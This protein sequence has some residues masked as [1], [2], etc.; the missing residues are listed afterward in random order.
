[1]K[2][3][4]IFPVLVTITLSV[5]SLIIFFITYHPQI[6]PTKYIKQLEDVS[7]FNNRIT[8]KATTHLPDNKNLSGYGLRMFDTD[9]NFISS[10]SY[11]STN[12]NFKCY[13]SLVNANEYQDKVGLLLFLGDKLLEYKVDNNLN[14]QQ[15][16]TYKL[17]PFSMINIPVEFSISDTDSTNIN[18]N[19]WIVYLYLLDKEPQ[20]NFHIPYFYLT[21][22][23]Q[24]ILEDYDSTSPKS[25]VVQTKTIP[26]IKNLSKNNSRIVIIE[27]AEEENN[28][29]QSSIIKVK[30]N[31]IVKFNLK[32]FMSES[33]MYSTFVFF[34]NYPVEFE[35]SN[36]LIWRA[37]KN[38]MLSY[39]F[40]IKIP[41]QTGHH[42]MYSI[43]VP[44]NNSNEYY[45]MTSEKIDVV[46][47][48]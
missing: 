6:N 43:S 16:F 27:K 29:F 21:M 24:I 39:D 1:M 44:L 35:N 25:N 28:L 22:K 3:V 2:R 19:L 4:V 8:K 7:P 34:D 37:E 11:I 14:N 38:S 36:R 12:T 46:V 23:K 18:R 26:V 20:K 33:C 15:F 13:V 42:T 48:D 31:T 10:Q 17:P 45:F 30:K 47:E 40:S 5:I 41:T 9:G 32:A